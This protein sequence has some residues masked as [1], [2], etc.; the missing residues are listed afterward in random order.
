MLKSNSSSLVPYVVLHEYD[1]RFIIII[2]ASSSS[3]P[4]PTPAASLIFLIK[5]E[6][7]TQTYARASLAAPRDRSIL[8]DELASPSERRHATLFARSS[9]FLVV[10]A[11]PPVNPPTNCKSLY[12]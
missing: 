12:Y 2:S 7:I 10:A 8:Q 5:I 9:W 4:S 1:R 11:S 3:S 6:I